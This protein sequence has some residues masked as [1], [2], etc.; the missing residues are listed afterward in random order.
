MGSCSTPTLRGRL[1]RAAGGG[2]RWRRCVAGRLNGLRRRAAR[3]IRETPTLLITTAEQ[4]L[5]NHALARNSSGRRRW[6]FWR[7][8]RSN[9]G[10]S[11][12]CSKGKITA[13]IHAADSEIGRYGWLVEL[14]G[15]KAGR[16]IFNGYP[17]G[18]EVNTA[19]QHGGPYPSTS[20]GRTTSVGTAAIQRFLRPIAYQNYPDELLPAELREGNPR[21]IVRMVDGKVS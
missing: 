13:S 2:A 4:F 1:R 5:A 12:R 21:Q 20:D 3:V 15:P 6:W 19:I 9:C 11:R 7:D 8:P 16:L 10:S 14:L 18:V 17:T